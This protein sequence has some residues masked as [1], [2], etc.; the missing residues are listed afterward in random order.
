VEDIISSLAFIPML[1]YAKV[2]KTAD[3]VES[4]KRVKGLL[5]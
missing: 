2:G 5:E 3:I 1:F 4:V